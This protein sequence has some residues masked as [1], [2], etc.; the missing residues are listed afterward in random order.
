MSFPKK[1]SRKITV[2]NHKYLWI[3][4]G[5]SGY[6]KWI[7]LSI[8]S[9]EIN[10]Q[11]LF[12]QFNYDT[13]NTTS[14]E[15]PNPITPFI[16]RQTIIYGLKNGYNPKEKGSD[17]NL[18]NLSNKLNLKISGQENTR[19]LVRKVEN[20][21]LAQFVYSPKENS[22]VVIR[23]SVEKILKDCNEYVLNEKWFLGFKIMI[24]NL[25]KIKFKIDYEIQ[26]LIKQIFKN[27]NI[28]WKKD[29]NWVDEFEIITELYEKS[30]GVFKNQK[31]N[32]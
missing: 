10:G 2:D 22:D 17:F 7:D 8:M 32:N 9:A 29:F 1:K 21:S 12:A 27:E 25:H 14:Y 5:K 28:D 31:R 20:L 11:K 23:N 15:F 4:K 3:A 26:N 18:G 13:D 6:N 19:R 24:E 30:S 16:V